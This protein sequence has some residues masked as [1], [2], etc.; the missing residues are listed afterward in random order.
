MRELR[1]EIAIR[2]KRIIELESEVVFLKGEIK[3]VGHRKL[4]NTTDKINIAMERRFAAFVWYRDRVL[5]STLSAVQTA[6]VLAI[7]YLSFGGQ[8]P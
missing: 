7:L 6:I 1:N 8:L 4:Q 5:P 3:G 2:E